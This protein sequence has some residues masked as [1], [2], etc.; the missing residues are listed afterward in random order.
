MPRISVE[1]VSFVDEYQPGF[2]ECRFQ[3]AHGHVHVVVEKVPVVTTEDLRSNSQYPLLGAIECT[4][5]EEYKDDSGR[6]L[7]VVNT[8]LPWHIESSTG[9][10]KFELLSSQ[11]LGR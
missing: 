4:M 6:S 3:D 9:Q 7:V 2:V 1:I 11:V 10:T 8:E 5:E